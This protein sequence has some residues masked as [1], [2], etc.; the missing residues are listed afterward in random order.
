MTGAQ[1]AE[2]VGIPANSAVVR[3]DPRVDLKDLRIDTFSRSDRREQPTSETYSGVRIMHVP[4]G[5]VVSY[6]DTKS[7]IKNR[8]AALRAL[9]VR[10]HES[11]WA[12]QREVA[13]NEVI[14]IETGDH[15]IVTTS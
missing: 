6:H 7:Q 8:A 11:G 15:F 9:R 13:V 4:S 1:I 2:L 10:L 12:K 14:G 3:L 5:L